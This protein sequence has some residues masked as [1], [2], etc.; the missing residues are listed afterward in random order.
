MVEHRLCSQLLLR[1]Y[2]AQLVVT[3]TASSVG[4]THGRVGWD[5]MGAGG[6]G[7]G[8]L[9]VPLGYPHWSREK[10]TGIHTGEHVL[11][12]TLEGDM[13]THTCREGEDEAHVQGRGG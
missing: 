5:G 9:G 13:L 8:M 2:A 11:R 3:C 4:W 7:Q 6:G 10:E 1:R 12:N